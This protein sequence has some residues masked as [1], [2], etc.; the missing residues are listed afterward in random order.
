MK[1]SAAFNEDESAV[2]VMVG[3]SSLTIDRDVKIKAEESAAA[4]SL[5]KEE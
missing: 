4:L 3:I 2:S 5:E 1:V